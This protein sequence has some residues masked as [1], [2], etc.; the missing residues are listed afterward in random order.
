MV[1]PFEFDPGLAESVPTPRAKRARRS[2]GGSSTLLE[3]ADKAGVSLK[4]ASRAMN[5]EPNV[6][7]E[8]RQRVYD[9]ARELDF[10]LNAVASML[11]RG[12]SSEFVGLVTGDLENP[13]YFSLAKGVEIA[14]REHGSQLTIASS[15]EDPKRERQLIDELVARHVRGI[16][17]VSAMVSHETLAY[18]SE[19]GIPLVF[20]DRPGRGIEAPSV[21]LD[22]RAGARAAVEHLIEHGHRDIAFVGEYSWPASHEERYAGYVEAM[23]AHGLAP[24]EPHL[25][26]NVHGV[27]RAKEVVLEMLTGEAPPTALFTSNNQVTVG[28]LYALSELHSQV[29]IVGF[30]DFDFAEL[31][32]VTVVSHDPVELGRRAAKYLFEPQSTAK[33]ELILI[34]TTII[35]RG[36]GERMPVRSH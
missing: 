26:E 2:H 21:V 1:A 19:R 9:A 33:K 31:V 24:D 13:F 22:N 32:G 29:A 6:R 15:D 17:L 4:T 23:L 28:A 35:P 11:G 5:G 7:P 25:R 36:S 27:S 20:V 16:L 14:A 34:P 3:V 18:V 12:I 8:T 30:D 10:Q